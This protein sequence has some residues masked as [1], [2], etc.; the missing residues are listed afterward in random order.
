LP[1]PIRQINKH[2]DVLAR[3]DGRQRTTIDRFQ[4]E[5]NNVVRLLDTAYDAVGTGRLGRID[6]RLLIQP[7]LL[8]DQ[9]EREQPID[10]TPGRG[11][12]RG[13]GITENLTNR[14]QQV[15]ADYVYCSGR[16]PRET[17]L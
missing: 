16:I 6:V 13:Y 17:C 12:L 1:S 10:L 5:G 7:R 14:G 3:C 4:N 15:L 2:R 8:R 11:D 9:L